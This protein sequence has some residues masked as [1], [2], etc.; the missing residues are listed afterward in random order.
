MAR[1]VSMDTTNLV[2][3]GSLLAIPTAMHVLRPSSP[4]GAASNENSSASRAAPSVEHPG[5]AAG[6]A[7]FEQIDS[8]RRAH[9]FAV[10]AGY[11]LIGSEDAFAVLLDDL[12]RRKWIAVFG[13]LRVAKDVQFEHQ[14]ARDALEMAQLLHAVFSVVDGTV[15]CEIGSLKVIGESYVDAAIKAVVLHRSMYEGKRQQEAGCA[16]EQL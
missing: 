6:D 9:R 8:V 14:A 7:Q 10:A 16:R 15:Q 5:L 3:L 13:D 11:M 4:E 2:V 12:D 1:S